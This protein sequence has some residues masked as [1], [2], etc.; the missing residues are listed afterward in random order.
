[1]GL[2]DVAKSGG[3]NEMMGSRNLIEIQA[4]DTRQAMKDKVAM[5]SKMVSDRSFFI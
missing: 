5:S 2:R 4:M 3:G 1:V